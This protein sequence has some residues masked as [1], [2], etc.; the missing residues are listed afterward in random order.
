MADTR[1]ITIEI[2]G[3]S[4]NASSQKPF[5]DDE[6]NED[7]YKAL[8]EA[9]KRQF[10][11][12]E[13]PS[14]SNTASF[15]LYD[16]IKSS[17]QIFKT[18][19]ETSVNRNFSLTENYIGQQ[20]YQNTKNIINKGKSF[21]GSLATG[22][23]AGAATGGVGG[24]VIGSVIGAVTWGA[25]QQIQH[26]TDLSSYYQQLNAANFNTQFNRTRAGLV[27]EGRGTDN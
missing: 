4:S 20:D 21:I 3:R 9:K 8:K 1:K 13:G 10:K 22:F 14:F 15:I 25:N 26:K 27:N 18:S 23:V 11:R 24:S 19:I 5:D 2:L 7:P 6:E 17:I 16:G 12:P